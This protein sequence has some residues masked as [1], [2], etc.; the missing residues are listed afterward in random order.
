MRQ[1]ASVKRLIFQWQKGWSIVSTLFF[2]NKN[3]SHLFSVLDYSG[4]YHT[5]RLTSQ[6]W[7]Y[8]SEN[9]LG[10]YSYLLGYETKIL[11]ELKDCQDIR[12][13][14]SKRGVFADAINIVMKDKHEVRRT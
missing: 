11:L 14:K 4:A 9:Y 3:S 7:L 10:F 13:A 8:I 5:N 2:H 6:G 12:K 1:E